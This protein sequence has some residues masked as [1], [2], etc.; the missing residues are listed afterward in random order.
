MIVITNAILLFL[1]AFGQYMPAGNPHSPVSGGGSTP[2]LIQECTTPNTSIGTGG[3]L[4][5]TFGATIG[6][7]HAVFCGDR[8]AVTSTVTM[9]GDA[10]GYTQITN[11]PVNWTGTAWAGFWYNLNTTGGG[12]TNVLH[13]SAASGNTFLN[14]QEWSG[15]LTTG[16]DV[17]DASGGKIVVNTAMTSNSVT[18]TINGDLCIGYMTTGGSPTALTAGTSWTLGARNGALIQ[19]VLES[20]I[21]ATAGSIAATATVAPVETTFTTIACFKPA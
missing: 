20:Q 11:D 9:T 16:F 19:P 4:T 1:L 3:T 18:T 2:V 21:L 17:S 12:T 13:S 8:Y 10:T 6:V 15:V 7:G 5:C 14:C